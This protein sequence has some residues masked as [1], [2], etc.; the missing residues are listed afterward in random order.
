MNES[1]QEIQRS[2]KNLVSTINPNFYSIMSLLSTHK[3]TAQDNKK[4]SFNPSSNEIS[5]P[6]IF[7][8]CLSTLKYH[9][10][11]NHVSLNVPTFSL[12][13][14]YQVSLKNCA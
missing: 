3:K 12:S 2:Y 4:E 1:L 6:K 14:F 13:R 11:S 9:P 10:K 5:L 8:L 7:T